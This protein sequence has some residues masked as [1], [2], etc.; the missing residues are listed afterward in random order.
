MEIKKEWLSEE[1]FPFTGWNFSHLDNRWDCDKLSWDYKK[2]IQKNL[3]Q[4]M[5][6]L[7]LGTGD[8]KFLLSLNHPY[9]NTF[10]TEGY[11]PNYE[12]CKKTLLPLGIGVKFI[13]DDDLIKYPNEKFDIIINRHESF[14]IDEIYRT[15][16]SDGIFITQ[17]VGGLN[18]N[19]LS[20]KLF[21]NFTPSY[22]K[23]NINHIVPSL[24]KKGFN[25][26]SQ[27]EEYPKIRFYDIGA[28]IYF[29]KIIKWEFPDFLVKNSI[30]ELNQ[31]NLEIEKNGY[32]EG[33]EHRYLIVAKKK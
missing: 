5:I 26:I 13:A 27:K 32:L 8:G 20:K 15:L 29:A 9:K 12:L 24:L 16:K 14:S 33:T 7:D 22:P 2:I 30:Y 19:D 28:F 11:Y 3:K 25:I 4:N 17:Q 23:N 21:P 18:N 31:I 1:Q 6:L 10:V